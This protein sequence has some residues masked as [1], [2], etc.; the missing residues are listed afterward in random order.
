M[1][2]R[3]ASAISFRTA[4]SRTSIEDG[5]RPSMPAFH[6][7]SRAR[8]A[9]QMIDGMAVGELRGRG[10]DRVGCIEAAQQ[11]AD[12]RQTGDLFIDGWD[13]MLSSRLRELRFVA[14]ESPDSLL[15]MQ[16]FASR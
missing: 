15:S 11:T 2:F 7:C 6:S 4:E 10:H 12:L 13:D 14:S 8:E 3:L 9:E 16:T 1:P 5:A